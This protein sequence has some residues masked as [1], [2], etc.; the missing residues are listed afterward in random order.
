MPTYNSSI[1]LKINLSAGSTTL[2]T[3]QF[4]EAIVDEI[5]DVLDTH[6]TENADSFQI[7][8]ENVIAELIPST[9][10]S[11]Y[12]PMSSLAESN[13]TASYTPVSPPNITVS[14]Y[15]PLRR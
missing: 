5:N 8:F 1:L 4:A 6:L 9:S 3:E 15:T 7:D 2:N 13:S 10:A 14:G 11:S 12:T